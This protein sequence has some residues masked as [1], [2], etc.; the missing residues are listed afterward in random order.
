M[1]YS[2][3]SNRR[4]HWY[5]ML[6]IG[7]KKLLTLA[8]MLGLLVLAF[9]GV[10]VFYT[11]RAMDYDIRRVTETQGSGML[12]DAENQPIAALSGKENRPLLW[13]EL[14]Q[15]LINAFVAREDEDYFNHS[16]VVL[17]AVFRSILRNLSSMRYEQGASTITMQLTRNAFELGTDKSL[18]RKMIEI[19]LAQRVERNY[20]KQTILL[21]YLSRIFFGQGCYGVRAAAE[22]YYGKSVRELSLGEC[23]TLAGLVRGPSIFNPEHSISAAT[24]VRNET[25]QR[26]QDCGFITPEQCQEEQNAPIVLRRGT[27]EEDAAPTYPSMWAHAELDK[28]QNQI[29]KTTG[30]DA[31]TNLNLPLQQYVEQEV[32]NALSALE[33]PAHYPDSWKALADTP[34][35]AEAEQK[36]YAKLKRPKELKARGND[37]DFTGLLQ[38]CALVVDARNGHKGNVLA[39]AGGRCAA[40]G[41]DR[42][43]ERVFPG[44]T[45]APLVFCCACLPGGGNLHIVARSAE[46]TGASLTYDVVYSF[47]DT[48]KLEDTPLPDRE[49]ETDLYNGLFPMRKLDLA[50]L[51]FVLQNQGRGYKLGLINTL[52]RAGSSDI[53]YRY[54]PE[55]APE[56]IRRE[57]ATTVASLPPFVTPEAQPVSLNE[58]LPNGYGQFTML[59]RNKGVCVFVWMGFDDHA[60]PLAAS[61]ELRALLPRTAKNLS[62]CIY[63]K[64]REELRKKL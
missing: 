43:Q 30:L 47:F 62:R 28:L 41:R 64:A 2:Q 35:A 16:G 39:V 56:Y 36:A 7:Q 26:M 38:C 58:T 52:W 29:G 24:A 44:R 34:E 13:E 5:R 8:T 3:T 9:L 46:V 19:V 27:P 53:I 60:H 14:P 21:Q 10:L 63:E 33:T 17:S 12:Y 61:K 11:A 42:W 25:L 15:D 6:S 55:K 51:L 57:S 59:Y 31:V 1:F 22:H 50:R 4:K 54:E 40:D 18:D 20:N 48:L 49:H 45:A 32:E 37:N 23:A